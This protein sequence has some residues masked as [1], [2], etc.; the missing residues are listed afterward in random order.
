[1]MALAA[2]CGPNLGIAGEQAA[3]VGKTRGDV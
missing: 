3:A 1:M 2:N